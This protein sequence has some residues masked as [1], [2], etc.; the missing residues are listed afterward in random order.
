[1]GIGGFFLWMFYIRLYR[2]PPE[3]SGVVHLILSK[4]H[5]RW[6]VL[7]WRQFEG[8]AGFTVF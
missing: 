5:F 3:P 6:Q 2:G 4:G 7:Q 1:V 8:F